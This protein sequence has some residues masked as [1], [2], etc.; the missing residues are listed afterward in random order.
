MKEAYL[1][2][3]ATKKRAGDKKM[4]GDHLPVAIKGRLLLLGKDLDHQVQAYIASLRETGGVVNKAVVIAA[5]T[6]IDR[7]HNSNLLATNGGHIVLSKH[8][9]KYMLERIGY[10]KRKVTS[11][12]KVTVENLS[13]LK[14]QYLLD[15][16]G[17]V[18]MEEI[19][20]DLILN[21]DQTAIHYVPVSSWTMAKEGCK[22]ISIAGADDKRQI[23]AVFAATMS[24]K[25][26]PP[27]LVYQG[28][29]K[30]CLSSVSFPNDWD[31][32]FTQNQCFIRKIIAP[33]VEEMRE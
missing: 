25:L 26:L 4:S 16:N 14:Q 19:P 5:T 15:I 31:V 33:Y 22:K 11:K 21:W 24:G 2:E 13:T 27:Q 1:C 29:T 10:V 17:T 23:T 28:K 6:E 8:W 7:R 20:Q 9:A 30:G 18:E 12:A 32:T 3:L